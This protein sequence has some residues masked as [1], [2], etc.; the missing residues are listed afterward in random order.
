MVVTGHVFGLFPSGFNCCLI[1][2]E[3]PHVLNSP[4]NSVANAMQ[5]VIYSLPKVASTDSLSNKGLIVGAL[6]RWLIL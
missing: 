5:A 4:L 3:N 2:T 1:I 6:L